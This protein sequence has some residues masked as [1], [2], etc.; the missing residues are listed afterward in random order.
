ME[1]ITKRCPKC[2][3][4]YQVFQPKSHDYGSP[5]RICKKCGNE[6]IDKDF[7]EIAVSGMVKEDAEKVNPAFY[8]LYIIPICCFGLDI[9]AREFSLSWFGFIITAIISIFVYNQANS[10]NE[11]MEFLLKEK[12]LSKKR[13][14]NPYYA[15][16]L[17]VLKYKV[18]DKYLVS[19][20]SVKLGIQSNP[21]IIAQNTQ[22]TAEDKLEEIYKKAGIKPTVVISDYKK[23][24]IDIIVDAINDCLPA[25]ES[26]L[27]SRHNEFSDHDSAIYRRAESSIDSD[28]FKAV[29]MTALANFGE[30]RFLAASFITK[31]VSG[32]YKGYGR[33]LAGELFSYV[34]PNLM[35]KDFLKDDDIVESLNGKQIEAIEEVFERVVGQKKNNIVI[36]RAI[37]KMEN[38]AFQEETKVE[39]AVEK[40][41]EITASA[42]TI[43]RNQDNSVSEQKQSNEQTENFK[44]CRKCGAKIP[45]DSDFCPKCGTKV[46]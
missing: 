23:E 9:A 41:R 20:D 28:Y 39:M 34:Y 6:F 2:G 18:Q 46:I 12:V 22:I 32:N 15:A 4:A 25:Y 40:T 33:C 14:S 3:H 29:N 5:Y 36:K 17:K 35:N 1:Y 13:L 38:K 30:R 21:W 11:R 37:E 42:E 10:Y 16:A 7:I 43:K 8:F 24:I 31:E 19:L 27:K 26:D 44:F 45:A